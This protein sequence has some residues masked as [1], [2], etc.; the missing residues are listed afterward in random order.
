MGVDSA[1]PALSDGEADLIVRAQKGDRHA[2]AALMGAHKHDLYRFV[3]RRERDAEE[4]YDIV[5]EAFVS[6]WGAIAGV[7]PDRPFR[8]WLRTIA[9]NKCRDRARRAKARRAVWNPCAPG[10]DLNMPDERPGP[11]EETADRNELAVLRKALEALPS[12][13]RE[14][15]ML[16]AV[17]GL[18]QAAASATLK[19]TI[20]AL[21]YR[22]F[23]ARELLAIEMQRLG[24][25][26]GAAQ[27]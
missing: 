13:L 17:D 1:A 7:D 21:E 16:T 3:R 24:V 12:H 5:Q 2:F 10:E 18:S 6:A 27:D 15:L 26:R 22:V 11:E 23:R 14:A 20:K 4:A 19:C 25:Q 8:A 9:L